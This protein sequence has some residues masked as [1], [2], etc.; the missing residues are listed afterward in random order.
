MTAVP[1][2]AVSLHHR[3]AL[4]EYH[5]IELPRDSKINSLA[6]HHWSHNMCLAWKIQ[7]L[8]PSGKLLCSPR[9]CRLCNDSKMQ[10]LCT[11]EC[12]RHKLLQGILSWELGCRN[13]Q[14][15]ARS[16]FEGPVA[17]A[18]PNHAKFPHSRIGTKHAGSRAQQLRVGNLRA[19]GINAALGAGTPRAQYAF[20][21][22]TNR[23]CGAG[24]RSR[25]TPW[26]AAIALR[27][28]PYSID[29][30]RSDALAD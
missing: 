18:N 3:R 10:L 1:G 23:S 27:N 11:V 14:R 22:L 19:I 15:T 9:N 25:R 5:P 20:K 2:K 4:N 16:A 17:A 30:I 29:A 24:S 8:H 6:V 12:H 7:S 28:F 26:C 21:C 13:Y